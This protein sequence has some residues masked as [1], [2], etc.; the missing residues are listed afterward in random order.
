MRFLVLL[1]L[2]L[3]TLI[4]E[5]T[6][7]QDV[8]SSFVGAAVGAGNL[9]EPLLE[10]CAGS[11][12]E[13]SWSGSLEVRGG[14]DF[15]AVAVEGRASFH[16]A[17][18]LP[19]DD[20]FSSS[21]AHESGIHT[22]VEYPFEQSGLTATTLQLRSLLPVPGL[23]ASLGGGWAWSQELPLVVIGAGYRTGR[24]LR[25]GVDAELLLFRIPLD[26]VTREWDQGEIVR[27]MSTRREHEWDAGLELRFVVERVLLR[28]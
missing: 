27:T 20:C 10:N 11:R 25:L 13:R 28:R 12:N 26:R 7:A 6:A 16:D 5:T 9:P 1:F 17:L 14:L 21:P 24:Q 18:P 23:T 4:P 3:G 2:F 8:R 19:G 15:G 22:D